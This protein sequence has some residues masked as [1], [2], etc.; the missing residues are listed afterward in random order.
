MTDATD[1]SAALAAV[2]PDEIRCR[3]SALPGPAER[4]IDALLPEERAH[5]ARAIPKRRNEFAVGRSLARELL[6]ELGFPDFPLLPGADRA[7]R[8]PLGIAGSIAH[9]SRQCVVA[10]VRAGRIAGI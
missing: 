3:G 6:G 5:I 1:A 8:W 7:P 2:L 10:V 9:D 4:A